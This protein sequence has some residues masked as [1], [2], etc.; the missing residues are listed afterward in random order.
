MSAGALPMDRVVKQDPLFASVNLFFTERQWRYDGWYKYRFWT[1]VQYWPGNNKAHYSVNLL[2]VHFSIELID[3]G[4]QPDVCGS[5][6]LQE[7]YSKNWMRC[8]S[9]KVV[10]EALSP[11][12]T[13]SQGMKKTKHP[14]VNQVMWLTKMPQLFLVAQLLQ[15]LCASDINCHKS[16]H[17]IALHLLCNWMCFQGPWAKIPSF[18]VSEEKFLHSSINKIA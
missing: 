3:W 18:Q 1:T 13:G 8:N 12:L 6:L 14:T 11:A 15:N 5:V 10:H 17:V 9:L 2:H 4:C 7:V 16:G